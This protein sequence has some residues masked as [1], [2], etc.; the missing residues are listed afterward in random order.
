MWYLSSWARWAFKEIA[1]KYKG[2][3]RD[4]FGVLQQ[5]KRMQNLDHEKPGQPWKRLVIEAGK[6]ISMKDL[7]NDQDSDSDESCFSNSINLESGDHSSEPRDEDSRPLKRIKYE[8]CY[9]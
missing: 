3:V 6:R 2:S 5:L 1:A 4:D 8:W 9:A 7:E